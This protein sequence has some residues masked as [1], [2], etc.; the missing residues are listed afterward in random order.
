M[1]GFNSGLIRGCIAL[2]IIALTGGAALAQ[3]DYPSKPVH[4]IVPFGPGG[5]SDFVARIIQPKLSELLGQQIVIENRAGAAGNVGM[6]VAANSAPDGYTLFLGN[7]G[8][9]AINPSVFQKTL[10]VR[11]LK[12]F[13]PISLVAD[14]P[15]VLI[16]NPSFA[17][18]TVRGFIE[19]VK[20]NQG[21]LAFASPGAGSMNRL[22]MELFR[23]I[24]G[25]MDMIHVPYKAGA[26]QAVADVIGGQVPVMF[27]TMSSAMGHIKSGR[28]RAL[29]VTTKNRLPQL[30]EVP[31]LVEQGYDMVASSWQGLLAPAG[32]PAPIVA[33]LHAAVLKTMAAPE[34]AQRYSNGGVLVLASPSPEA[35]GGF[36]ESETLRWAKVVKD[37]G[38]IAD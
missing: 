22:E 11:P 20:A 12:D 24:V 1:R 6:G 9:L 33:K 10:R 32:T 14:T 36:I 25:G 37:S 17:G 8:T 5:A 13:A 38:A 21:K 18:Q 2:G 23:G 16:A 31:T 7:V 19:Q 28:L 29:A 27:T 34:V 35:F 3:G 15:D 26:G 30:P 4:V